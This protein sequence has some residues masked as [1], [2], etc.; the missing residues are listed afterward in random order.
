MLGQL[1]TEMD[2]LADNSG[3]VVLAATNRAAAIDPALTRPGRFDL[4]LPI[5]M[6]DTQARH[7]ILQVHLNGRPVG[8]DVRVK[9]LAA[10]TAGFSGA[11][12][13]NLVSRAARIALRRSLQSTHTE[14]TLTAADFATALAEIAE[15]ERSRNSDFIRSTETIDAQ[16]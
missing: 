4:V 16:T 15:S 3:I 1:L 11:A 14:S 5:P 6:P 12:L 8:S 7:A 10:A 13:A 2:G 9:D